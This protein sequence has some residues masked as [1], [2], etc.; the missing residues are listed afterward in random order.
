LQCRLASPLAIALLA[1]GSTTCAYAQEALP[2]GEPPHVYIDCAELLRKELS[3]MDMPAATPTRTPRLQLFRM[4]SGFLA[5]PLG[6]VS[7]DDPPAEDPSRKAD[8]DDVAFMLFAMGNHVPYLDMYRRGDP[9]GFGYY[10]IYSQMQLFDAG[11]TNISV[12]VRAVT[13]MG[14][15]SGGVASGRTVLSPAL[16]C[17]HDLGDGVAIQAFVGQHLDSCSRWREQFHAG[18]R[19]GL[20]VQHPVPFLEF[21]ADQGLFVFV[22]A[23]GQYRLDSSHS[24]L[25]G[26]AWEVIP[27]LQYRLNSACWMSMG[28]SRYSF[29]SATWQY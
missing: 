7:D 17:F 12:A 4:P 16:A 9:G 13:P 6:L 15:E 10:H 28:F 1:V 25:R 11:T 26:T 5:T 21:S 23:L 24:D 22:Q 14:M 29:L 19:C 18:F 2:P 20:A 3:L 27:G 8:D